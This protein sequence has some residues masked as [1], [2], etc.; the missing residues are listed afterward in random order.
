[1][2]ELNLMNRGHDIWIYIYICMYDTIWSGHVNAY[3]HIYNTWCVYIYIYELTSSWHH[4]MLTPLLFLR[5]A[6]PRGRSIEGLEN[7]TVKI[8]GR[9]LGVWRRW[10][11]NRFPTGSHFTQ[12]E[13]TRF[14]PVY[15][16]VW[17]NLAKV[18]QKVGQRCKT[19]CHTPSPSWPL[20]KDWTFWSWCFIAGV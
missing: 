2:E 15:R 5:R 10:V 3:V 13:N 4:I 17:K 18:W 19:H 7:A 6:F 9:D 11:W 1:M 8:A 12:K 16:R 20:R 14:D